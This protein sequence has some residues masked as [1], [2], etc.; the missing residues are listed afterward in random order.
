MVAKSNENVDTITN[1]IGNREAPIDSTKSTKS[2]SPTLSEVN[3]STMTCIGGLFKDRA[4]SQQTAEL[5]LQS[6][7][8]GTR[9]QYNPYW[10]LYCTERQI[11]SISAPMEVWVN[12]LIEL[13][14]SGVGYSAQYTAFLSCS[15]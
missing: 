7:R 4:L 1:P 14:D 2:G 13:Y 5:A 3:P 11:D 9:K 6:W 12:F 10:Q 15:S 8:E